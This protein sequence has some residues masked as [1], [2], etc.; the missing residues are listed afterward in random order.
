MAAFF[1]CRDFNAR[2]GLV[3]H[4]ND[5]A[6]IIPRSNKRDDACQDNLKDTD[7]AR[8]ETER[9]LPSAARLIR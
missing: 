9:L 3:C 1:I 7:Q 2:T 8:D 4:R 6:G 5:V